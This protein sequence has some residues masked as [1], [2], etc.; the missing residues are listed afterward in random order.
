MLE[1]L[2]KLFAYDNWANRET[3]RSLQTTYDELDG[4]L[5]IMGH[6]I[7]CERLWLSRLQQDGR[8]IVVWPKLSVEECQGGIAALKFHW[9][10]YFRGLTDSNLAKTIAYVNSKGEPWE[11]RVEDVLMHV[12]MHSAYHRGQIAISVREAGYEPAYTDLIH[13]IRQGFVTDQTLAT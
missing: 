8:K 1:Y 3:L 4:P 9:I 12:V 11:S 6:I 13:V 7:G 2:K 5:R 10:E